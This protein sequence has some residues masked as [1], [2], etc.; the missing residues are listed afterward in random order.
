MGKNS[1][2]KKVNQEWNNKRW[3]MKKNLLAYMPGEDTTSHMFIKHHLA[4]EGIV[5]QHDESTA[6]ASQSACLAP[7]WNAHI[8]V[9]ATPLWSLDHVHVPYA[10]Y[11]SIAQDTRVVVIN[12][13]QLP[14]DMQGEP[15]SAPADIVDT[16]SVRTR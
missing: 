7:P 15:C 6:S 9:A 13:Q 5:S 10:E 16:Q 1:P 2:S 4:C 8:A 14:M 3:K 12:T 11:G